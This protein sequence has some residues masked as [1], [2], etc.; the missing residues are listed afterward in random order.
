MIRV[1]RIE[2]VDLRDWNRLVCQKSEGAIFQSTAWGNFWF[3]YAGSQMSYWVAL[4]ERG[5]PV[6]LMAVRTDGM[7]ADR[8]LE[9]PLQNYSL[10]LL[11]HITPCH[12]VQSGPMILDE[13]RTEEILGAFIR[14][15]IAFRRFPNIACVLKVITP[16]LDEE[17][18][19]IYRKVFQ[20]NGFREQILHTFTVDLCKDED[21][22]WRS[23]K[24]SARKAIRKEQ[25]RGV[26]VEKIENVEDLYEYYHVCRQV[27]DKMRLRTFSFDNWKYMWKWL[28][29]ID[30]VHMFIARYRDEIVGG[31]GIW[32]FNRNL[33]EFAS[34]T[35]PCPEKIN[36]GD[37]LKWEIIQ[38]GQRNG[39][40]TYDLAGVNINSSASRKEKQ[41]YQFKNKWG[42]HLQSFSLFSLKFF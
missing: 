18:C 3:E 16:I 34:I 8:F 20:K 42:G 15:L 21:A 29:P 40:L 9:R 37:I 23:L 28:K 1:I 36:V 19:Q 22:L 35:V 10:S 14:Q 6:G 30:S 39:Y 2:E 32:S 33:Y 26:I 31:L 5:T 38:W 25:K 27:R 11:R 17:G 7:A 41:I 13:G 12:L 24:R 4:D